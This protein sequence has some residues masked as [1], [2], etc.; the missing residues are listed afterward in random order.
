M[1]VRDAPRIAA[2]LVGYFKGIATRERMK[3]HLALSLA[4]DAARWSTETLSEWV[5]RCFH[6]NR[7]RPHGRLLLD[8][9]QPKE[10]SCFRN[11]RHPSPYDG[12]TICRGWATTSTKLEANYIDAAMR[13]T[14]DT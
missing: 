10:R 5:V 4:E 3:P 11:T 13:P 1:A 14:L 12:H 2:Q 8:L 6:G 9:T 7:A